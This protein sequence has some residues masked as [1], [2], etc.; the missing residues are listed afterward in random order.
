[1]KKKILL[2]GGSGFIGRN[3]LESFLAEKYDIYHPSRQELNLT[4]YDC[5]K[6]YFK[7]KTFDVVFHSATKP[8][9]Q[10]CKRHKGF[11]LFKY[12]NV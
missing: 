8:G 1:M 5:V 7:D 12:G 3:I 6:S 9:Q 11:I 4:D 2:T 10:K